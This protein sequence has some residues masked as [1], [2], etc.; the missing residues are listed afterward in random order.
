MF[1]CKKCG[2]HDIRYLGLDKNNRT[3]CRL[4][5][6]FQGEKA[7]QNNNLFDDEVKEHLDYSLSKEQE[8]ISNNILKAYQDN[9]NILIYAVCGAGK[10]ELVYKTIAYALSKGKQVGFTIPRRD[11]VIE[12]EERIKKAFPNNKV[13]SLYKDHTSDLIGDIVLL[14]THQLYRYENYFDLLIIDETDA[15]PYKNNSTL[16]HFFKKSIRGNYIM[17]SATPLEENIQEI[18]KENGAYFTLMTRYHKHPLIVPKVVLMPFLQ[19]LY[20]IIKLSKFVKNKLPVLVF[21]PTRDDCEGLYS[22]LKHFITGGFLVHSKRDDRG[23]TIERFKNGEYKYLVT[24]SVLERGVTVKNLQVIIYKCEHQIYDCS[25][26]IQ[27]SGRVGR[28]IDAWD[29]EVVYVTSKMTDEI[30]SSILKIKE[31]NTYVK[32]V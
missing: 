2:N 31:A 13:V 24:T 17:M 26:L 6:S 32:N 1:V 25:T 28:K 18:K 15:F 27:I 14:T 22:I 5:I 9:K 21:V 16:I 4:C 23:L 3:Y 20:I 11:V 30:D 8:T 7:K 12:L 10:T 29:G 19:E